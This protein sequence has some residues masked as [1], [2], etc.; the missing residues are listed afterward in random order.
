MNK[1]KC[2]YCGEM[3]KYKY[4]LDIH[5]SKRHKHDKIRGK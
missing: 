4:N 2:E 1:W 3:F 5:I